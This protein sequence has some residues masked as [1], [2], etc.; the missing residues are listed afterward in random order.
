VR[1]RL[2]LGYDGTQFHGWAAQ[3]GLRTV[4]GTLAE[5]LR[6]VLR[7]ADPPALTVA[8]RTDAGVHARGQVCH[9][10]VDQESLERAPGRS[11]RAPVESLLYRLAGVLPSDVV[12]HGVQVVPPTFDARFSA[13]SRRYAYR[14]AD[15]PWRPSPLRRHEV[16][17]LR[18]PL[19]AAR[20]ARATQPLLGEHDFLAFC[21]PRPEAS[22]VRTLQRLDCERTGPGTITVHVEAD[23]FCHHMVRAIVGALVAVGAGRRDPSWPAEVLAARRRDGA[24]TV[25][26]ALGLTLEHVQYPLDEHLA[27][28]AERTRRRRGPD[29]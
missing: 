28:Q 7:R 8:G 9:V 14:I 20:M 3:P 22:T 26:P 21:R 17:W 18:G 19:D 25:A 13:V 29:G 4:E 15:S 6:V 2:D 24:V 11:G 5:A 23:A 27:T 12:V 1:L 16:A 10:D